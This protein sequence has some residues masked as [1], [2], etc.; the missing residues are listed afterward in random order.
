MSP[1]KEAELCMLKKYIASLGGL[2]G[3][4]STHTSIHSFSGGFGGGGGAP[5]NQY[6]AS[7]VTIVLL[8]C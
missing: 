1:H 2:G 8:R 3:H 6:I 4:Y 5:T 7:D